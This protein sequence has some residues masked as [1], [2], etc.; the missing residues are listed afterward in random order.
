[1]IRSFL[2]EELKRTFLPGLAAAAGLAVFSLLLKPLISRFDNDPADLQNRVNVIVIFL[3]TILTSAG[4]STAF[5]LSFREGPLRLIENLPIAR[6]R[7]WI[8]RLL[9]CTLTTVSSLGL[10][11]V[12]Q[13]GV[14]DVERELVVVAMSVGLLIFCGGLCWGLV[15]RASSAIVMVLN[16][17]LLI[18]VVGFV[19]FLVKVGL[20]TE[21]AGHLDT[22]AAAAVISVGYVL[23]SFYC[24]MRGEFEVK[25]RRILNGVTMCGTLL[26]VFSSLLLSADLGAFGYSQQWTMAGQAGDAISASA[27]GQYLGLLLK[28]ERHHASTRA[29][30]IDVESGKIIKSFRQGS[31]RSLLWAQ[32]NS[33]MAFSDGTAFE[34]LL[35]TG[36]GTVRATRIFPTEETVL[37]RRRSMVGYSFK[38][39]KSGSYVIVNSLFP[40]RRWNGVTSLVQLDSATGP[41][42]LV[43]YA[44]DFRENYHPEVWLAREGFFF[45][46]GHEGNRF[47]IGAKVRSLNFS[48]G[49]FLF[50]SEAEMSAAQADLRQNVP[51]P[52]GVYVFSDVDATFDE[53]GWLYFLEADT[54][55]RTGRLLAR[56]KSDAEWKLVRHGVPLTEADLTL[57]SKLSGGYIAATG[58]GMWTGFHSGL[59]VQAY[60][61]SGAP[62]IYLRNLENGEPYDFPDPNTYSPSQKR[63]VHVLKAPQYF[64]IYPLRINGAQQHFL[65]RFLYR[66]GQG[67]PPTP[68]PLASRDSRTGGRFAFQGPAGIEVY[69]DAANRFT[70]KLPDGSTRPLWPQ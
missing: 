18:P 7:I 19:A 28:K 51:S 10:L 39:E 40:L 49:P 11:T 16:L 24:F 22:L 27:D 23:I 64:E 43:G 2:S 53:K 37:K 65:T 35:G 13:P 68:A 48:W 36:A 41:R 52:L 66:P 54:V 31:L 17:I 21:D 14:L 69:Q 1:V 70:A 55:A 4:G 6:Y 63:S 20:E 58:F 60:S 50:E 25:R 57:I 67:S 29:V 5:G 15:V 47:H 45:R 33:L 46:T 30:V 44:W 42:D 26:A 34:K 56:R 9:T 12:A 32:D 3:M 61:S 38:V 62:R 59:V 8:V